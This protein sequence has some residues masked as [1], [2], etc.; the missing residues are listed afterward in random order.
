MPDINKIEKPVNVTEQY[1]YGINMRL[2]ILIDMMSSFLQAYAEQ[3]GMAVE[4][5]KIQEPIQ[6][7]AQPKT[8][9][10]SS[11]KAGA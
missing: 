1:L 3:N 2:E 5:K 6:N 11:K 8:K 7:E 9:K 4:M 10:R